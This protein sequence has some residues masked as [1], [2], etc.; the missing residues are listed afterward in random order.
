MHG[1]VWGTRQNAYLDEFYPVVWLKIVP[2]AANCCPTESH[3]FLIFQPFFRQKFRI[4]ESKKILSTSWRSQTP[5]KPPSTHPP[6]QAKCTQVVWT[7]MDVWK[8]RFMV[9][10]ASSGENF[11]AGAAQR[12]GE[13]QRLTLTHLRANRLFCFGSNSHPNSCASFSLPRSSA[14]RLRR[15]L[16]FRSRSRE[17]SEPM[18]DGDARAHSQPK[19]KHRLLAPL[20]VL[21]SARLRRRQIPAPRVVVVPAAENAGLLLRE[22]A[23]W[24][25][26][27]RPLA[28]EQAEPHAALVL[29]LLPPCGRIVAPGQGAGAYFKAGKKNSKSAIL[30][31]AY[32]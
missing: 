3:R 18:E 6:D 5:P 11:A 25:A 10:Y 4:I 13:P 24:H 16:F 22:E 12:K 20:L 29:H 9:F 23:R 1:V 15:F 30:L 7:H 27:R 32:L 8:P 2:K 17:V 26:V 31:N 19:Y 21:L 14:L 28:L